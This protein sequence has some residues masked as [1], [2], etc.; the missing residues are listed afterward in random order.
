MLNHQESIDL[1]SQH[2]CREW[3][4]GPV[5]S[6]SVF[7]NST[8]TMHYIWPFMK[9]MLCCR[10]TVLFSFCSVFQIY[11]QFT[12]FLFQFLSLL[13][14][15]LRSLWGQW[16]W[17]RLHH[18]VEYTHTRCVTPHF[19]RSVHGVRSLTLYLPVY[20]QEQQRSHGGRQ[21][22]DLCPNQVVFLTV[23]LGETK[24]ESLFFTIL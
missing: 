14:P 16:M 24:G 6:W 21:R 5:V 13:R 9:K 7:D 4:S 22:G 2:L 20:C 10:V 3:L 15:R 17:R 1:I 12:T 23:A 18:S 11:S 19:T 8:F